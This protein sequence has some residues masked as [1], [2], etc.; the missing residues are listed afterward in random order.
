MSEFIFKL[1]DLGEGLVEAEIA[2]WMVKPGDRVEEED[3]ICAVMTD[4]AA[5]EL[6]APV[7]GQVLS[8]AG[9]PGDMVAVGSALIT[10]ELDSGQSATDDSADDS[11]SANTQDNTSAAAAATSAADA[12]SSVAPSGS[13]TTQPATDSRPAKVLTSPAIRHRAREAGIDLTQVHG[14]GPR[15]R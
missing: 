13:A 2:E 4:K 3:V 9:E 7:R 15:G 6:T 10:F 1:P 8:I 12:D 5:V 11:V 14:S